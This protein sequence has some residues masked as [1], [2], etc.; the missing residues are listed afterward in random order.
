MLLVNRNA[1]CPCGSG[2]KYKKCCLSKG[3]Y[4]KSSNEQPDP[5]ESFLSKQ[6]KALTLS[7]IAGLLLLPENHGKNLRLEK[8]AWYAAKYCSDKIQEF[9]TR[10]FQT[11]VGKHFVM[12]MMEDPAE[13]VFTANVSFMEGNSV[14]FPGIEADSYDVLE[15]L[16]LVIFQVESDFPNDYKHLIQGI[17]RVFLRII[18]TIARQAG[19][20]RYMAGKGIHR[21]PISFTRKLDVIRPYCFLPNILF[22][23]QSKE[24]A[25]LVESFQDF[26]ATGA[27]LTRPFNDFDDDNPLLNKPL[28]R[29]EG[30]YILAVPTSLPTALIRYLFTKAEHFSVFEKLVSAYHQ[31]NC[32]SITQHLFGIG[33][34]PAEKVLPNQDWGSY[35][36]FLKIDTDLYGHLIYLPDRTD[37]DGEFIEARI[38]NVANSLESSRSTSTKI[39]VLL[40]AGLSGDQIRVMFGE[41]PANVQLI[42]FTSFDLHLLLNDPAVNRLALWKFAKASRTARDLIRIVSTDRLDSFTFFLDNHESFFPS[43]EFINVMAIEPGYA[44][45]YRVKATQSSDKHTIIK[46]VNGGWGHIQV[47][48][49]AQYGPIYS[50][51]QPSPESW[52]ALDYYQSPIWIKN[53][54]AHSLETRRTADQFA[55]AILYWLLHLSGLD[56]LINIHNQL[57]LEIELIF[58]EKLIANDISEVDLKLID[59]N[60]INIEHSVTNLLSFTLNLPWQLMKPLMTGG[61]RAEQ[62]IM[63]Q[64]LRGLNQLYQGTTGYDAF[65]EETI[66]RIIAD[67]MSAPR[68]RMLLIIPAH[69]D[70]RSDPRWLPVNARDIPEADT[71]H[72]LQ[73]LT[74]Y[75]KPGTV[76]PEKIERTEDKN[77]ICHEIVE[78][79]VSHISTQLAEYNTTELVRHLILK[80][81]AIIYKREH[82]EILIPAQIACFSDYPSEVEKLKQSEKNLVQVALAIRCLIEFAAAVPANGSRVVTEDGVDELLAVMEQIFQW[83]A[84]S[85]AIRMGL[86]DMEMGLLPSGRI[87]TDKSFFDDYL[88]TFF[89]AYTEEQLTDHVEAFARQ[90][91]PV[92]VASRPSRTTD[93][94]IM[95]ELD[96]AFDAQFDVFL[97]EFISLHFILAQVA[98]SRKVSVLW[99]EEEELY[100]AVVESAPD[101]TRQAFDKAMHLLTLKPRKTLITPPR[102]YKQDDIYPWRCNREL[103]YLR[104]PVYKETKDNVTSYLFGFRHV[105]AALHNIMYLLHNG[106]LNDDKY[107]HFKTVFGRINH[108]K[109][110]EYRQQVYE[111]LH[112]HSA[113]KVIPHEVNIPDAEYGDIDVL[114][115]DEVNYIVYSLECKNTIPAK[116]IYEMKGELDKY[117]GRD[118]GGGMIVKHVKRH[119]WLEQHLT[120]LRAWLGL[121]DS[122]QFTLQS[123]VVTSV[124]I[125]AGYISKQKP[126][127]PIISFSAFK[128]RMRSDDNLR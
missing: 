123:I 41:M 59:S 34:R 5:I 73:T 26:V 62:L 111:W 115:W 11:F 46:N 86:D 28:V 25:I 6:N 18:N 30:G 45:T 114:A 44:H 113:L 7:A 9:D 120:Q 101:Y 65:S 38:H 58:D 4:E 10:A 117:F 71:S 89:H 109:G 35:E 84:M 36:S 87:G 13:S 2:K 127:L 90:Q 57:S 32:E 1:P 91:E 42:Q 79:L 125:P 83:G 54:Q 126:P 96:T 51:V 49:H 21:D 61:N 112:S 29:V 107:T 66:D 122:T 50:P 110:G 100:R 56:T 98:T 103:S 104:R 95:D 105:T 17:V 75:L 92:K 31:F 128:K 69:S 37:I 27:D 24:V 63:K 85:D 72:L 81:E 20:E 12:D 23:H 76:V 8:L 80:N 16:L 121:P 40:V 19:Y 60:T 33:W 68:R 108:I 74:S 94:V 118:L 70:A 14:V 53:V 48:K 67:E 52:L 55:E 88:A 64:V 15:R 82:D 78:G 3:T 124:E 106:R 77:K 22:E 43:D 99:I 116:N 102:N 47:E 39:L 119:Q 93:D 97:K